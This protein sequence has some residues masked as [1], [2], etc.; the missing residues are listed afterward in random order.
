M[1]LYEP[2]KMIFQQS[3]KQ[4]DDIFSSMEYHHVY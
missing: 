1:I 4:L 3:K 2:R